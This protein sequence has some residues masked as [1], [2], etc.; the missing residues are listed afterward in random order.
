DPTPLR[1][2]AD[3]TPAPYP[4]M[5]SVGHTESGQ[6]LLDLEHLGA[7]QVT[8]SAEEVAATCHT[9]AIELAASPLADTLQVVCVGFGHDLTHLERVTVV[10]RL[11]DALPLVEEKAQ[12]L[13]TETVTPMQGRLAAWGGDRWDPLVVIDPAPTPPEGAS[14]LLAAALRGRAVTAVVGYPTGDRWRFQIGEGTVRVEPL[15]YT[16]SRRNLTPTEQAGV[17]ALTAAAKDLDRTPQPNHPPLVEEAM[18][19]EPTSAG[20]HI[21]EAEPVTGPAAPSRDQ[22]SPLPSEEAE[23][24]L[25]VKVLGAV[26]LDGFTGRFSHSKCLE[27]VTYLAL[28]PRGADRDTLLEA[29][30]PDQAPSRKRIN[31]I[32]SRAR[33]TLGSDPEGE[34]YLPNL[35][36]D[37]HHHLNPKIGCDLDRFTHL[38]KQ[39]DRATTDEEAAHHLQAALELV[40]GPPFHGAGNDYAW[41]HTEGIVTHAIVAIDNAAHRL[42]QHALQNDHPEQATW[43]ARLGLLATW[44]CEECYRNLMRAAIHRNDPTALDAIYSE[45]TTLLDADQGPDAT[46]LLDP[47]TVEL[48]ERHR[49]RRRHA[50]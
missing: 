25:E 12:L 27:L 22:T 9:M 13:A 48:Y 10:D 17:A 34:L 11:S 15:G 42:A 36:P 28:H 39:A 43:A 29:L 4:A 33:S 46:S 47:E 19:D 37:N 7:V 14:T 31:T 49:R 8:G 18:A 44:A 16:L 35:A 20:M 23:Q 45:L 1:L 24:T 38:T 32:I 2:Y 21:D 41:A 40:E 5:V 26:H 30:W 6:L 3:T 50:G